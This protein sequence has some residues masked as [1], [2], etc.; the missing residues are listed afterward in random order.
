[1]KIV[2]KKKGAR[3]I[4]AAP[5]KVAKKAAPKKSSHWNETDEKR[6]WY[7]ANHYGKDIR[8]IAW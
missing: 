6:F 4:L 3:K 1:M 5:K 7:G 2:A 8:A